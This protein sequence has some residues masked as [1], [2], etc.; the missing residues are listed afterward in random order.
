MFHISGIND[1]LEK[2]L[3]FVWYN[4]FGDKDG[5]KLKN[6]KY[7]YIVEN[8][9]WNFKGIFYIFKVIFIINYALSY[10]VQ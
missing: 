7:Y 2:I 9:F 1:M 10:A 4:T 5:N 3:M 6:T 8:P